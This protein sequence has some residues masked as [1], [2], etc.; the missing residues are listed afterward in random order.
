MTSFQAYMESINL[1]Q[2]SSEPVHRYLDWRVAHGRPAEPTDTD[3]VDVR[4]YLMQLRT[5]ALTTESLRA[6]TDA[7]EAFYAWARDTGRI[8]TQP[9]RRVRLPSP[10]SQPGSDQTAPQFLGR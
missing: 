1:G 10:L 4:T 5:Q 3:D 8:S 9:I 6:H 2:S 7:I